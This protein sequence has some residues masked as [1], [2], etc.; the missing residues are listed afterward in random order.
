MTDKREEE[1]RDDSLLQVGL[2]LDDEKTEDIAE[3]IQELVEQDNQS[4]AIELFS[5]LRPGDQGEVIEELPVETRQGILTTLSPGEA[6]E[7]LEHLDSEDIATITEGMESSVLS[8]ILDEADSD[9]KADVL[10]QIPKERS[11][12]ILEEMEEVGDAIPLL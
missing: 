1:T 10:R 9:V 4:A 12:I 3:Q 7:I 11:Q 5:Q 2:P 8:D 6:A